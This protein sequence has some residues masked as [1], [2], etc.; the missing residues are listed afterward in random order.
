[1]ADE[2]LQNVLPL[3]VVTL[4]L[5]KPDYPGI[6]KSTPWL[7]MP[8]VLC[9][10]NTRSQC[11]SCP[12]SLHCHFIAPM[13]LN[14]QDKCVLVYHK[15]GFQLPVPSHYWEMI[16]SANLS[17][18]LYFLKLVQQNNGKN[19]PTSWFSF[20]QSGRMIISTRSNQIKMTQPQSPH[21]WPTHCHMCWVAPLP[22]VGFLALQLGN[23]LTSVLT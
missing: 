16:E 9:R 2:I 4:L 20:H 6:I 3:R 17:L 14:M 18:K 12:G 19:I 13:V 21:A 23:M 11:C 1:M 22:C 10:G 15:E 5:L 7:L 8:W